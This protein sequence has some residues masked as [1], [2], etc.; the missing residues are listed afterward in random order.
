MTNQALRPPA[1]GSSTSPRRGCFGSR[2][3]VSPT[4]C[5]GSGLPPTHSIPCLTRL[6]QRLGRPAHVMFIGD[7]RARI[8]FMKVRETLKLL[9]RRHILHDAYHTPKNATFVEHGRRMRCPSSTPM[10]HKTKFLKSVC[11]LEV[12]SDLV[13][14]NFYWAPYVSVGYADRLKAVDEDCRNGLA[15]PDLIIM[16]LG[17]WYAKMT[18]DG[19]KLARPERP[20][21]VH[22]RVEEGGARD[23]EPHRSHPVGVP[24]RRARLHGRLRQQVDRQRRHPGHQRRRHRNTAEGEAGCTG[25]S[26]RG[27]TISPMA[28]KCHK[29]PQKSHPVPKKTFLKLLS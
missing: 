11:Y 13:R 14:A 27:R 1:G 8:L 10:F 7:S 6:R 20:A 28:P 4:T 21:S 16:T 24:H 17:M 15:C 12:L 3:L 2:R 5:L 19:P 25:G 29:V 22:G 23:A 18:V 9:W 26:E